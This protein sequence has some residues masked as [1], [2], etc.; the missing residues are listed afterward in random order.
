MVQL[1]LLLLFISQDG[2]DER[3]ESN[4]VFVRRKCDEWLARGLPKLAQLQNHQI[5]IDEQDLKIDKEWQPFV[6]DQARSVS[7]NRP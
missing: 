5:T 6:N 2:T 7:L 4:L 3:P 1:T